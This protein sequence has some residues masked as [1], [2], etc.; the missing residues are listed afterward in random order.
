LLSNYKVGRRHAASVCRALIAALGFGYGGLEF[1][2]EFIEIDDQVFSASG[3]EVTIRMD[4]DV[5]VIT[6]VGKEWR[7]TSS[8]TRS[9]VLSELGKRK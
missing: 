1:L 5:R 9:I 2:V 3:G 4:C 8:S 6:F 7:D